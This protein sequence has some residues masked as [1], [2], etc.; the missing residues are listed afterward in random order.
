MGEGNDLIQI[1]IIFVTHK[2]NKHNFPARTVSSDF[3]DTDNMDHQFEVQSDSKTSQ[4]PDRFGFIL[5]QVFWSKW[6]LGFIRSSSDQIF[7]L[8]GKPHSSSKK[9]CI[10]EVD[11]Y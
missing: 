5:T 7:R 2:E 6:C 4:E 3:I 9:I 10:T 8:N 11:L 1:L